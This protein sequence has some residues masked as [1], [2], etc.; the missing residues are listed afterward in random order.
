M[1]YNDFALLQNDEIVKMAKE[2]YKRLSIEKQTSD[3]AKQILDTLDKTKNF[4]LKDKR[5]RIE[6]IQKKIEEIL[7]IKQN[8]KS[9]AKVL[10]FCDGI[11]QSIVLIVDYIKEYE[12]IDLIEIEN[13]KNLKVLLDI[14]KDLIDL[15]G[16]CR[17][18]K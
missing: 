10:N 2:Y 11:K 18:R 17:Y 4:A 3:L 6:K 9:T 7:N 12:N 15:I 5:S 16:E 8:S 1:E 14:I 13:Y